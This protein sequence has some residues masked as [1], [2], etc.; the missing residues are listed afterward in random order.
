[1]TLSDGKI[2][3]QQCILKLAPGFIALGSSRACPAR[4]LLYILIEAIELG[5]HGVKD[6]TL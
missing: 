2:A 6:G 3:H 5:N 1:M 4:E